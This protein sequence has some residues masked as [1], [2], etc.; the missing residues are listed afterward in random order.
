MVKNRVHAKIHTR[1][2]KVCYSTVK[3]YAGDVTTGEQHPIN[4]DVGPGYLCIFNAGGNN[5]LFKL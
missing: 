2:I 4:V 1:E 5:L 3:M